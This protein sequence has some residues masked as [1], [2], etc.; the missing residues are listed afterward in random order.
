MKHG[1]VY[2]SLIFL[3][4][5]TRCNEET[6]KKNNINDQQIIVDALPAQLDK[7][8]HQVM[9]LGSFHFNRNRDASDH[10]SNQH[11]DVTSEENQKEIAALTTEIIESYKPTLVMVEW[12]P[13]IQNAIDSLY[14][15][16]RKENWDLG[17]HETF[18][19]GFRVASN[20]G[21]AKVYCIDNRP[22]Q[23]ETVATLDDWEA[24]GDSLNQRELWTE[25]D[26]HNA[27]YNNYLDSLKSELSVKE[28]LHLL[29][30]EEIQKRNKMFWLTG[31]V[32]L[33]YGDRYIGADL[34]GHWYRRNARIFVNARNL[35]KS[36][37]ERIL[38]IYGNAHKWILD[39]MFEGSSEFEVIQ[40]ASILE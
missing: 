19:I 31:L 35:C 38:I 14:N 18:Q 23:P 9:V 17:K 5:L 28:Y 15:E 21:H 32:N 27:M 12:M 6:Q 40:P 11:M 36:T 3:I 7:Y 30:S 16:Y 29:N 24:Y 37:E 4:I 10:V 33:G 2:A 8:K 13:R 26:T 1:F 34:T 39:E 22:P 20:L 25:Y